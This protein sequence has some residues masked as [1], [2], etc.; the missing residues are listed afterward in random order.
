MPLSP[1]QEALTRRYQ[2]LLT[3]VSLR[4]IAALVAAWDALDGFR[5]D[6]LPGWVQAATPPTVAAK[7]AA[8]SLATG[9]AAVILG[10]SAPAVRPSEVATGFDM[11]RSFITVRSA[12]SD[13]HTFTEARQMGLSVA[14]A[15]AHDLTV[16]TARE[17]SNVAAEK[18]GTRI[19]GWLRTAEAD[20]C[21]W[22]RRRDGLVYDDF[23]TAKVG[24]DRCG[25]SVTPVA[26]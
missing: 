12:L 17:A 9:Y 2:R 26:A 24:H 20:P 4:T 14:E 15:Q 18:T 5:D 1:E 22:C 16:R 25:C 19:G 3:G 23:D 13:G 6:D 10:V 7:A 21:P 11:E 8:T